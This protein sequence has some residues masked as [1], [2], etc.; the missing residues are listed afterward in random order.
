[1]IPATLEE[2][3]PAI[4]ALL[5]QEDKDF[6]LKAE[7]LDDALTAFHHSLGRHLRNEW[8]L[9]WNSDLAQHLRASHGIDHPDDMSDFIMKQYVRSRYPTLWERLSNTETT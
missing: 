2:C 4:D 7:N 8:N 5:V 6:L 9:W 3:F 1:M